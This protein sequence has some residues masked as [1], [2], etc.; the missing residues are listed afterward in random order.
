MNLFSDDFISN[1][2]NDPINR[3]I[4]LCNITL[5]NISYNEP[6][7][8]SAESYLNLIEAYALLSELIE[9]EILPFQINYFQLSGDK[10]QDES[11]IF[12]LIMDL[13]ERCNKESTKLHFERLRSH[14]K[15]SLSNVFHYEFTQGDLDRI[16]TLINELRNAVAEAPDLENDHRQRLLK[17]LENLQSELHKKVSDLDRFWGLIGDAGVVTGKLGDDAKPLVDR[18][19]EIADIIW[20]TQSKAEELPSGT[21]PTLIEHKTD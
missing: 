9:V 20:R 3:T 15:T 7:G 19:R 18:I 14:F 1:L 2:K 10:N 13:K 5:S 8:F 16:Q 12:Q 6:E 11:N 4:E 17:R 21:Q